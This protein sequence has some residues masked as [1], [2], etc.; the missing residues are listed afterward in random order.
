MRAI[1]VIELLQSENGENG[2]ASVLMM[3]RMPLL[4]LAGFLAL[5]TSTIA[6][7]QTTARAAATEFEVA[8]IKPNNSQHSPTLNPVVLMVLRNGA[9]FTRNGQY[10]M[11]GINAT[12]PSVLIQAA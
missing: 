11:Q 9:I 7:S 10:W 12:T 1:R 2:S 8:S 4:F 3:S 6:Q 5:L